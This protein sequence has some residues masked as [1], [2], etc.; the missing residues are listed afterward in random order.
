MPDDSFASQFNYP[1]SESFVHDSLFSLI[2]TRADASPKAV[3]VRFLNPGDLDKWNEITYI[4]LTENVDFY[5][6]GL[7]KNGASENV[8][9][10]VFLEPCAEIVSSILA[11]V[12]YI[13]IFLLFLVLKKLTL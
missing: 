5:A 1:E 13:V 2:K 3:A 12:P 4:E 6:E 7:R 10:N 11:W 9:I 8:L